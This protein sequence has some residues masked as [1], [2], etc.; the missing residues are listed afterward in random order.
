M[1]EILLPLPLPQPV[2][3]A[4]LPSQASLV[5]LNMVVLASN[6]LDADLAWR[7]LWGLGFKLSPFTEIGGVLVEIVKEIGL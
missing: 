1:D 7:G 2:T 4:G 5:L 6:D 3:L